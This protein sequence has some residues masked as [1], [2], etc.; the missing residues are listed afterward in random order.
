MDLALKQL[1][2]RPS[3]SMGTRKPKPAGGTVLDRLNKVAEISR[4]QL[5]LARMVQRGRAKRSAR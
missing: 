3:A 4:S 5:E 1:T 2:R